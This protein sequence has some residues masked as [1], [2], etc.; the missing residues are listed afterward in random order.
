MKA[1]VFFTDFCDGKVIHDSYSAEFEEDADGEELNILNV[2]PEM[3][4]QE[5]IGFGGAITEAVGITLNQMGQENA[6]KIIDSYFSKENGIGYRLIRTPIDSCDFGDEMYEADSDPN[7]TE[8]QN[9]SMEQPDKYIVPY[10][11]MACTA[12]G[13]NLPIMLSPWSP[14]AYMKTNNS[15]INGGHL[16]KECYL[17]WARYL[18]RYMNEYKSRGLNLRAI[19]IQN[20]PNASQTWDSCLFT[21]DE[22]KEFLS[23]YLYPQMQKE[24][25]SD[26]EIFIWDHNKERIFDRAKEEIDE[27]TNSK[28]DG[29]AFHWYS[30]DHF[31]ALRMV[32]EQYPDK[33]LIFTEGCIEYSRFEPDSLANAKRYAHD[34]IGDL[35]A[36]I[37]GLIDWNIV[38]NKEGG[39]NYVG[40]FCESPIMCDIEK[41]EIFYKLSYFYISHFSRFILPGAVKIGTSIYSD[42]VDAVGFENTYGSLEIVALNRQAET[43]PLVIRLHNE[44]LKIV[45]K[46][47][48]FLTI[49]IKRT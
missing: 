35:N 1:D 7:D 24:N 5:I 13:E 25:L 36:G 48:E 23:Q 6:K 14:P 38:L 44:L 19:S 9:F 18:C 17:A 46:G 42:E 34:I 11:R 31:D 29:I 16:K 32:H 8:F 22:E 40:N 30:G 39:P 47:N 37:N 4:Y 41:K 33:K 26:I 43:K 2:Y 28:I 15:R 3:K 20:E 45:M 10:I 49:S 21:G 12:A 27:E